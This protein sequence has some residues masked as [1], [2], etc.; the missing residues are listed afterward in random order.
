MRGYQV[1]QQCSTLE[2]PDVLHD[3]ILVLG[4]K[5]FHPCDRVQLGTVPAL[6]VVSRHFPKQPAISADNWLIRM[7]KVPWDIKGEPGDTWRKG[8]AL[9]TY[10]YL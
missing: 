10:L 5:T 4:H 2:S 7:R 3:V 8:T 9:G 1:R 6:P